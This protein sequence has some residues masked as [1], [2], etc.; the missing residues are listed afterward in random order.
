MSS[1]DNAV[2]EINALRAEVERLQA[3]VE[4]ARGFILGGPGSWDR[5]REA[6]EAL[7]RQEQEGES[8][9]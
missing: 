4:A 2:D 9:E 3:V 1:L 6:V 7:D 5:L 8:D